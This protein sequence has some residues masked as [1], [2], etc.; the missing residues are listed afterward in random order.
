M[1]LHRKIEN[2]SSKS[3]NNLNKGLKKIFSLAKLLQNKRN[4]F[5]TRYIKNSLKS[6]KCKLGKKMSK[7]SGELQRNLGEIMKNMHFNQRIRN[8]FYAE[9]LLRLDS[10]VNLLKFVVN[11]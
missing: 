10:K 5:Q 2:V 7:R 11:V 4:K 1:N 3:N 8:V 9:K 6:L